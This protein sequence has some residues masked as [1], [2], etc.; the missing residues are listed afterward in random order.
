MRMPLQGVW[1][2]IR[3]N[4]PFYASAI[5][6]GV[7]A[8]LVRGRF[9]PQLDM[10]TGFLLIIIVLPTSI[11][12]LVSFY[13]YDVSRLYDLG[14]L[15]GLPHHRPERIVNVN[16][17][18][19][20]TSLLI[21]NKFKDAEMAACDFYDPVK[22]TE[23]SIRR[24]R[25]AFPPYPNTLRVSTGEMPFVN[26]SADMVLVIF[27]AHE[28]RNSEE[29]NAFFTELR[30]IVRPS[31]TVVVVEHLRDIAN[32][33]AYNIGALHFHSRATWLDSFGTSRLVVDRETKITPF[34]TVFFLSKHGT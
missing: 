28:I 1:N 4:W 21:R 22:H 6:L 9:G 10:L 13:V 25:K 24:A 14:W 18:F 17:G 33:V 12:L 30:R 5:G 32:F 19:D 7:L 27:S 2:V 26:D 34:V 11:S 31:G 16:A 8:L 20:E 3:F 15:N 23:L 29:R